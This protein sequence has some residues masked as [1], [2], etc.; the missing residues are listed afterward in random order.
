MYL[1]LTE[2]KSDR[3]ICVPVLSFCTIRSSHKLISF[4]LPYSVL[5]FRFRYFITFLH[6]QSKTKYALRGLTN[7]TIRLT[8]HTI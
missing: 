7:H 3:Y 5:A 6:L 2:C 8:N 4:R 1:L